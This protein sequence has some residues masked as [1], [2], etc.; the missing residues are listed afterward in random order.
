MKTIPSPLRDER[1]QR[2][3]E[4]SNKLIEEEMSLLIVGPQEKVDEGSLSLEM[5]LELSKRYT[6]VKHIP[7]LSFQ[8]E[9]GLTSVNPEILSIPFNH[10]ILG[11]ENMSTRE[12]IKKKLIA[13]SE[14]IDTIYQERAIDVDSGD[15]PPEDERFRKLMDA[16]LFLEMINLECVV[17]PKKEM[18]SLTDE[19][20][21]AAT[22][23]DSADEEMTEELDRCVDALRTLTKDNTE[24]SGQDI[25]SNIPRY[26]LTKD[27]LDTLAHLV[28]SYKSITP[29]H[30]VS[31]KEMDQA[32]DLLVRVRE[33]GI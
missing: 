26:L 8:V 30:G 15:I 18:K 3:I 4:E 33:N 28:I 25:P 2:F 27:E 5:L 7:P 11:D 22:L 14:L 13:A 32:L 19:L 17:I 16:R 31:H 29:P 20:Y 21:N 6:K 24:S 1:A 23:I 12:M 9:H 10:Q